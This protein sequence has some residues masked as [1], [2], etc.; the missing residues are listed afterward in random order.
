MTTGRLKVGIMSFAHPHAGNYI[1]ALLSR[2]DVDIL[3]SDPGAATAPSGEIRGAEYAAQ[4]GAPYVDSYEELFRWQPDAVIVCSENAHHRVDAEAGARAGAHVLCEKPLATTVAD[5]RAI[6]DACEEAGV[7]LMTAFPMRFTP[8][9][10]AARAA[11]RD[12]RIGEIVGA[13][14]TNNG[15]LPVGG[16]SWFVDS[17]LAGG[18]ALV[19]LTVHIADLLDAVLAPEVPELVYAATNRI[20]HSENSAVTNE[21]GGLVNVTYSDGTIATIDCS[22]SQPDSAA[23]WGGLTLQLIGT[24]GSIDIDPFALRVEGVDEANA[25]GFWLGYGANNSV[26]LI[27]EFITAIRDGRQPEPSGQ[28]GLRAVEIVAAAQESAATRSAVSFGEAPSD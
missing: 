26:P 14:G 10:E 15:K 21:T 12:G 24:E 19:D 9:F 28:A 6:V 5:A 25:N 22:W 2:G 18:G 8:M 7:L 27:N 16:R 13:T 4:H 3:A 11:I 20:L 17:E 1:S 23:S